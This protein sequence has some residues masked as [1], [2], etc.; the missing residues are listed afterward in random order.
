MELVFFYVSAET[1]GVISFFMSLAN[2]L[3]LV[4]SSKSFLVALT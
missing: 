2:F 3:M 1:K 4:Q